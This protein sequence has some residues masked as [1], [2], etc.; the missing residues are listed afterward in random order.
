MTDNLASENLKHIAKVSIDVL[1]EL[2]GKGTELSS[3]TLFKALESHEEIKALKWAEDSVPG[4]PIQTAEL[5]PIVQS[6]DLKSQVEKQRYQKDQLLKQIDSLEMQR[7]ET[8][9]FYKRGLLFLIKQLDVDKNSDISAALKTLQASLSEDAAYSQIAVAF[10]QFK[11][12]AMKEGLHSPARPKS[13]SKTKPSFLSKLFAGQDQDSRKEKEQAHGT[14]LQHLKAAYQHILDELKLNLGQQYLDTLLQIEKRVT[15]STAI[16]ELLSVRKDILVQIQQ[17]VE[18]VGTERE[19]AVGFI[20]EIGQRLIEVEKHVLSSIDHSSRLYQ[21]NQN[22]TQKLES[23]LGALRTSLDYSKTLIELKEAVVS[24]LETINAI[25]TAKSKQDDGFRTDADQQI[26]ILR[27]SMGLMKDKIQAA[28]NRACRLE[29]EIL[30]DPLTGAYNRRAYDRRITEEFHRFQRY[31]NIFSLL[32][33]DVDHFK[34]INDNYGHP[35]GDKCLKEIIARVGI[36]LRKCDFLARYG[37]EEFVV[38][39]PE[40]NRDQGRIVGEKIRQQVEKIEFIHK[41]ETIHITVSIGVTQ[42]A[43]ED[44]NTETIFTRLDQN[45]YAAKNSGR[46]AVVVQ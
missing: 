36:L 24:K 25:I 7:S 35:V 41:G 4:T 18:N 8:E 28:E 22:F 9:T 39:L 38:I 12:A 2:A 34:K 3:E 20:K 13:A 10:N 42:V 29:Q 43:A 15:M 45:M 30:K 1:K 21:T 32:L 5:A 17:F 37:G 23:H 40:T 31:K 46:N 44:K 14:A 19:L 33:F 11:D 26:E 16:E 27:Q 6:D